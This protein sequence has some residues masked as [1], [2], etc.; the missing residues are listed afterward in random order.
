MPCTDPGYSEWIKN[1]QEEAMKSHFDILN[2]AMETN[3]KLTRLLCFLC[4]QIEAG[5]HANF[6]QPETK[7]L[8]EWWAEHKK[9]DNGEK[10]CRKCK[11]LLKPDI[12]ELCD[13]SHKNH[14]EDQSVCCD[15]YGKSWEG[16]QDMGR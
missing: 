2:K 1:N 3:N 6:Q 10:Y 13:G 9:S 8:W 14:I 11:I 15:C 5:E 7:E 4:K 12:C 16:F